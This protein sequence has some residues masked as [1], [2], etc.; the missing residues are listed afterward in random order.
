MN[1]ELIEKQLKL[2][3]LFFGTWALFLGN[4]I[5]LHNVIFN[6]ITTG[7]A[8]YTVEDVNDLRN[9]AFIIIS[10]FTVLQMWAIFKYILKK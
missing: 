3:G 6:T 1:K 2:L 5:M 7:L 9:L 4:M 10:V 8:P